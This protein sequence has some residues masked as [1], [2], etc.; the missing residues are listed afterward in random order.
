MMRLHYEI[1]T[2][3]S[4]K[5]SIGD[6]YKNFSV[7]GHGNFIYLCHNTENNIIR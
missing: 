4:E 3:N 1:F 7:N 5:S 6:K 2:K